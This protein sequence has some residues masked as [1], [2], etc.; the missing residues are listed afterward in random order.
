MWVIPSHW[1]GDWENV[2]C[3]GGRVFPRWLNCRYVAKWWCWVVFER[4]LINNQ[5][6]VS[7]FF[8]FHPYLGK[9]SNL[10]SIFQMG[11]NHQP[12]KL[13]QG[14][15]FTSTSFFL[16]ETDFGES[17]I[18]WFW[19]GEFTWPFK[20][21]LVTSNFGP[22]WALRTCERCDNF[23]WVSKMKSLATRWSATN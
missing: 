16:H 22:I 14:D 1:L 20:G 4:V 3:D 17:W 21:L 10:T 6:V 7:S 19:D 11:W 13:C 5:V 2:P 23:R 18:P 15:I 12:D 9:I 8:Y